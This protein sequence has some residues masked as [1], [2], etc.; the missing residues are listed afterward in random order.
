MSMANTTLYETPWKISFIDECKHVTLEIRIG[1]GNNVLLFCIKHVFK[2][3]NILC[4]YYH[5]RSWCIATP[6]IGFVTM[7]HSSKF[8]SHWDTN[9]WLCHIPMYLKDYITLWHPSIAMLECN[10][11]QLICHNMTYINVSLTLWHSS[12][13]TSYPDNQWGFISE[14]VI[15]PSLG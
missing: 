4:M 5:Q 11:D 2:G 12:K 3:K 14:C 8:M 15:H 13:L 7:W 1:G 10:V 9:Q 6:M